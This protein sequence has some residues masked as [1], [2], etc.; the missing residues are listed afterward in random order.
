MTA[1]GPANA[2][3]PDSVAAALDDLAESV[4]R[5]VQNAGKLLDGT[6]SA[7]H[8]ASDLSWYSAKALGWAQEL[9]GC[10]ARLASRTA[11]PGGG[12]RL[13]VPNPEITT[14]V[15][16][17]VP[18][19]PITLQAE[20]FRAVGWGAA[21]AIN[22]SDVTLASPVLQPGQD[23]FT[24]TVKSDNLPA[25]ACRRTLVYE[26]SVTDTQTGAPVS[27]PIRFVRPADPR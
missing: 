14:T 15:A 10:W 8:A 9:M 25:A 24:I 13:P 20:S 22:A 5:A 11:S 18:Q 23:E 4:D 17:S 12:P 21:Y 26:G 27:D 6:Y 2:S 3:S 7:G 19:R 16:S 1:P